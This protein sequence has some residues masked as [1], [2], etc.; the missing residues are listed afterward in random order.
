MSASDT[1]VPALSRAFTSTNTAVAPDCASSRASS[2]GRPC[3]PSPRCFC[4]LRFIGG[5]TASGFGGTA[6]TT[7]GFRSAPA[8]PAGGSVD[9]GV[10]AAIDVVEA[11]SNSTG[12][13]VEVAAGATSP[14]VILLR[15][16]GRVAAA[17]DCD[18]AT[19]AV[20]AL[21]GCMGSAVEVD[22]ALGAGAATVDVGHE[23]SACRGAAE[24]GDDSDEELLSYAATSELMAA[25]DV[26]WFSA[27]DCAGVFCR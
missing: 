26:A 21:D 7:G 1:D 3:T 15:V 25:V 13:C 22:S 17:N 24:S 6:G 18:I 2:S 9:A 16:G 5:R 10:G 11:S 12:G 14:E 27:V 19:G 20:A 4:R 8:A 23:E